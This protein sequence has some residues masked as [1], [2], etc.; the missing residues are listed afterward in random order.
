MSKKKLVFCLINS[1]RIIV[2]MFFLY[3]RIA[4]LFLDT[5]GKTGLGNETHQA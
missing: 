4:P 1:E 5:K 3:L 2:F